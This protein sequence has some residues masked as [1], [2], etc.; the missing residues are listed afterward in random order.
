MNILMFVQHVV[1]V[2]GL[3]RLLLIKKGKVLYR[4][5]VKIVMEQATSVAQ[6]HKCQKELTQTRR[7]IIYNHHF[8]FFII[9]LDVRSNAIDV[10]TNDG[11][12]SFF[13][14]QKGYVFAVIHK[15]VLC[16]DGR[17]A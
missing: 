7:L 2:E 17:A 12:G 10:E 4:R 11:L 1:H 8:S 9:I 16:Q 14:L 6:F 5:S 15:E 13:G 3:E